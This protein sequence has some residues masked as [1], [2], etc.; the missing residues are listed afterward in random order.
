VQEEV[1]IAARVAAYFCDFHALRTVSISLRVCSSHEGHEVDAAI[2]ACVGPC[3]MLVASAAPDPSVA[4][5]ALPVAVRL[6]DAHHNL[7]STL[8]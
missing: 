7:G 5:Q 1:D 6:P 4:E 2:D 3:A 8:A